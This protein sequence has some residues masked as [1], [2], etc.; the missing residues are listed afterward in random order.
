MFAVTVHYYE[1][2]GDESSG[3]T[4]SL[5]SSVETFDNE[6]DARRFIEEEIDWESTELV[7]CPALNISEPGTYAAMRKK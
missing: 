7:E 4:P 2:N 5:E 6:A 3:Y 1:W